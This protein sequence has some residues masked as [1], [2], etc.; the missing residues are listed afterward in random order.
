MSELNTHLTE[1]ER[2]ERILAKPIGNYVYTFINYGFDE[3]RFIDKKPI[4]QDAVHEV[5]E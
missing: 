4:D 2:N 3:Y 1:T 5:D